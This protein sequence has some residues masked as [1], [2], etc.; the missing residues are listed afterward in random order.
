M[1]ATRRMHISNIAE[2]VLAG[3]RFVSF[4]VAMEGQLISSIDAPV[5]GGRISW[6]HAAYLGFADFDHAARSNLA[7]EVEQV[8][9]PPPRRGH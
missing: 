4:D 7:V 8:L 2:T 9:T 5:L 1:A 6:S 3:R